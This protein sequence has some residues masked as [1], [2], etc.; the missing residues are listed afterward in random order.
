MLCYYAGLRKTEATRLEA[1]HVNWSQNYLLVTGKGNKERIVPMHRKLCVY[2]RKRPKSGFLFTNPLR[3]A[4]DKAGLDQ[5]VYMHLL[6]HGFG[7][8]GIQS[9]INLRTMQLLMG[10]SSSQMTE[11]YT[12]LAAQFLTEEM[13]KFGRSKK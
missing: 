8:H 12:T 1:K 11:R 2:L 4:A 7:T 10:H 5:H 6:R 9:G 13:R 3:R